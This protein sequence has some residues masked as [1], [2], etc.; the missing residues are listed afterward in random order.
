MKSINNPVFYLL[1]LI[2]VF[3]VASALSQDLTQYV[4][5]LSGT[6]PA[7]TV[8]AKKHS[9]AGSEKNANTIPSVSLPFAM[10]QWTAQTRTS[11]KK[12]IPP[13]YYNDSLVTG[14]RATHWISGSCMQ[15][16]GSFTIMPVVGKLKTRVSEYAMP[17]S[18]DNE[19]ATPYYY[20]LNTPS[21]S[22]EITSTLRCGIIRFTMLQDDSLYVLIIPNSDYGEGTVQIIPQSNE[23]LASNP[24][25]RIYQGWGEPAGFSG[26]CYIKTDKQIGSSGTFSG[27]GLFPEKAVTGQKESGA[28]AGFYL[29]KGERL[30]VYMGTSFCSAE[31]SGKNLQSEAGNKQFDDIKKEAKAKWQQ[32]LSAIEVKSDDERS[33]KIF[34][35][36]LYHAMQQPRLYNDVDGAYPAFSRSYTLKQLDRGNYYDDFSMWDIY[37]AQLPLFEILDPVLIND[38]VQ[39]IIMKGQEGGWM[40]VFPCWNNYT[41]AMIGDHTSAFIASAFAKNIRDY[42]VKEAYRLLRKNAFDIADSADYINGK[43][44]RALPSYIQYGYIP[45]ED[46]VQNAF[47]KKEQVSRTLEYAYDDHALATMAKALGMTGDYNALYKRSLNYKNVFCKSVGMVRGRHADGRWA[48]SFHPDKRE[49]YI[50]EGTP[51]Q[52]TFYV[53]HDVAGLAQLM[54]GRKQ[55]EQSLDSLFQKNEYWHGNEPGHQIPFMYNY[56][57]APWKTQKV[58]REILQTEYNDGAGGLSGNDDAG[59]MSAWYVFAAIGFYPVD[60]VSGNYILCAPV[61]DNIRIPLP[62]DRVFEIICHKNAPTDQYI[63]SIKLNGKLYSKNYI[64]HSDLVKGGQFEI[65]LQSGPSSGWG[66]AVK[67]QPPG[68]AK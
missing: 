68:L 8:A 46:S 5:P 6:A 48:E 42:D 4:Q 52:Y 22:T 36:A 7:T 13:Y 63:S 59:Q 41:A 14:F 40:P 66:T 50:T 67:H 9:E 57:A 55:L 31:G 11:E 2:S 45:M 34:Y 60:P 27:R 30:T 47:H 23:I 61:F 21:V 15:D 38:M 54:G 62:R 32:A 16:Y 33:K 26:W 65:Y 39:S 44:R 19:T 56:T 53:P 25:H 49:Q 51:R 24:V 37:R 17:F 35:T 20:Q 29:K 18:H 12:C 64:R 28:Y 58:V 1:F 3:P 10:T 43:G